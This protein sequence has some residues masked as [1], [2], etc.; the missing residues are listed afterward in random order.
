MVDSDELIGTTECLPYRRSVV[1]T[2][3]V[4]TG[5]PMYSFISPVR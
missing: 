5:V 1:L 3:A 4:I 2:D